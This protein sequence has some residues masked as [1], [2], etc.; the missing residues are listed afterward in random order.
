[1]CILICIGL[2]DSIIVVVAITTII[3]QLLR[4]FHIYLT[5]KCAEKQLLYTFGW[6]IVSVNMLSIAV[7]RKN[8]FKLC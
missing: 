6:P 7:V 3:M 2:I 1:M 4:W 8:K 5:S